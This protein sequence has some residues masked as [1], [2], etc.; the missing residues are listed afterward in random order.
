MSNSTIQ[1]YDKLPTN[2]LS[3]ELLEELMNLRLNLLDTIEYKQ[4]QPACTNDSIKTIISPLLIQNDHLIGWKSSSKALE[5]DNTSHFM[6]AVAFCKTDSQRLWFANLEA[7]LYYQRV[8]S[9]NNNNNNNNNI[10]FEIL[11]IMN[12][13]ITIVSEI[14]DNLNAK[15]NFKDEFL[16]IG[17]IGSGIDIDIDNNYN[18]FKIPFEYVLNLIPTMNYFINKGFVY[19]NQNQIANIIETVFR[20]KLINKLVNLS[21][22]IEQIYADKRISS[23]VK[24]LE[25]KR[26]LDALNKSTNS[27]KK[28]I[29]YGMSF[30]LQ[31]IENLAQESFPLCMQILHRSLT[32]ESHLKHNGRLQYG[33]FLKGVGL[34]LE[35]SMKF[36]KVKFEKKTKADKFDKE[37]AYNI[38]HSYGKEGKRTN[39]PPWSCKKIQSMSM[40]SN[41]E[42]HGCP[43]KVFSEEKLRMVLYDLKFKELEVIK[44]MDKKKSNEYSIACMRHFEAKY[45]NFPYEK[46][47][48]HPN[49]YYES[50]VD[51][52]KKSMKNKKKIEYDSNN[53]EITDEDLMII[54]DS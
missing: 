41:I 39:Y 47:G 44:I 23:L 22:S 48:I 14:N 25:A 42:A 30:S 5:N 51:I 6:L 3:I 43:Y 11:R 8:V 18:V 31:D 52:K 9:Y 7:K 26:E 36:W 24:K 21:K 32:V 46:V 20:D 19:I 49:S 12:I 1:L 13:P 28:G 38:R 33:L 27:L 37:Y 4:H 50:S 35:E 53:K 15:I 34:S 45:P 54:V 2:Q 16:N 17:G 10:P 40:P 29:S